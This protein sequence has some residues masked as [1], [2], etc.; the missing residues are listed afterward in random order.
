[1]GEVFVVNKRMVI[2]L[3]THLDWSFFHDFFRANRMELKNNIPI[4]GIMYT[5][6]H[7]INFLLQQYLRIINFI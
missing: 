7:F 2:S 1:M 6:C 3:L 4:G 5:F